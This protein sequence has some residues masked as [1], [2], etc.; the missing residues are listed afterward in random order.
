MKLSPSDILGTLK[1]DCPP[2]VIKKRKNFFF[3]TGNHSSLLL[4]NLK[5]LKLKKV[6]PF[7]HHSIPISNISCS[8]N[9]NFLALGNTLHILEMSIPITRF[10]VFKNPISFVFL[11]K[12]FL[13][14]FSKKEKKAILFN[15]SN[16]KIIARIFFP[17]NTSILEINNRNQAKF[18]LYIGTKE[19]K[20]EIWSL[21]RFE[22]IV[23]IVFF[24]S[25]LIRFLKP[26]ENLKKIVVGKNKKDLIVLNLKPKK[27]FPNFKKQGKK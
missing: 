17:K 3:L 19:G 26:N 18:E 16:L 14:C 13:L 11:K 27:K 7:L 5:N 20:I 8:K 21:L 24:P 6:S 4:Y 25:F 10:S 1:G 15:A 23:S 22:K 2:L 9:R 12:N